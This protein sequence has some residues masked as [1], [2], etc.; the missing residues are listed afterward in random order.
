MP[1][2][3]GLWFALAGGVAA[4]AGLSARQRARRLRRNGVAA[5]ATAVPARF[6]DDE[7]PAGSSALT[8]IQYTLADGQMMERASPRPARKSAW[9]RPGQKVLVWYHPGDPQDVLVYGREG[10]LADRAFLLIGVL[11][12][13][14]GIGIAAFGG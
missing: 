2:V 4:L 10:R 5:W 9:L 6:S 8:M 12:I 13:F 7:Q 3:I 14:I 11:F 1:V